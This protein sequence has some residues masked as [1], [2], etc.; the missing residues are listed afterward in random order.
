MMQET[1]RRRTSTVARRRS[2]RDRC[3]N[4]STGATLL[5][6]D[7]LASRRR[8]PVMPVERIDELARGGSARLA[9]LKRDM[10]RR[11]TCRRGDRLRRR[12]RSSGKR[13][14]PRRR[15]LQREQAVADGA[16]E[17]WPRRHWPQA[18]HAEGTAGRRRSVS[19]RGSRRWPRREAAT[20]MPATPTYH[21]RLARDLH[22]RHQHRP[23]AGP[24]PLDR[25]REE[26]R[27]PPAW[28]SITSG[29]G[30]SARRSSRPSSTSA[31]TASR[32]RIPSCSTG[33]PSSSWSATGSMKRHPPPDRDQ[34]R[35]S[36]AVAA[37]MPADAAAAIRT[38]ACSGG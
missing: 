23:P 17:A 12:S 14:P 24:G 8:L 27:S 6:F 11:G 28:P 30:T 36:H 1:R 7:S 35:L 33:W 2:S 25:R 37:T 19:R 20:K 34:Q 31:S 38:I 16:E 32:R 10:L 3:G 21:A 13:P 5:E 22:R 29:C 15:R 18:P 26:S 9:E 4:G